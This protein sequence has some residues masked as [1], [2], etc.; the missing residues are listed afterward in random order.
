MSEARANVPTVFWDTPI[1]IKSLSVPI[2]D[3]IW[4]ALSFPKIP[5]HPKWTYHC[6]LQ[7][8]LVHG[9]STR[10]RPVTMT[11]HL[12][13]PRTVDMILQALFAYT[14]CANKPVRWWWTAVLLLYS[15]VN[16]WR[17]LNLLFNQKNGTL[18]FLTCRDTSV[19]TQWGVICWDS[20]SYQEIYLLAVKVSP[21]MFCVFGHVSS[22]NPAGYCHVKVQEHALRRA[23]DCN[24]FVAKAK[25]NK[26]KNICIHVHILISLGIISY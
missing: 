20:G 1:A 11:T 24:T 21:L 23:K 3:S 22:N 16:M 2:V 5:R 9:T 7:L 6:A 12:S 4:E 19:V 10:A 18:I 13:S 8:L 25:Q 17:P 14:T 26:A 15:H